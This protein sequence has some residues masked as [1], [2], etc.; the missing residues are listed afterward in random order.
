MGSTLYQSLI[1]REIVTK[2]IK[3]GLGAPTHPRLECTYN[4]K[5][6][7]RKTLKRKVLK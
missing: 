7:W 5:K 1:K 6:K 3:K 4:S 2:R